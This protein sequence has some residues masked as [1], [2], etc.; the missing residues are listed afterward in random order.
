MHAAVM[1]VLI[2]VAREVELIPAGNTPAHLVEP[3][4]W[5]GLE[6]LAGEASA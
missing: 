1:Q 2:A 4:G 5:C 3:L 6:R